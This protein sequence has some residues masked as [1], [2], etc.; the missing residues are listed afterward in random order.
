MTSALD[1][2]AEVG[3]LLNEVKRLTQIT[4]HALARKL[5]V[6]VDEIRAAEA[7]GAALPRSALRTLSAFYEG[8]VE[9]QRSLCSPRVKAPVVEEGVFRG[10][11][12]ELLARL[13]S[14]S[15]D[16]I[17][18]DIPYG[19]S[20]D[21][22]DVLHD[23]SNRALLGSSPAQK[24]AGKVFSK[25]RKPINGWS[26]Q[27][28]QIP[29][30]Y[31]EWCRGWARQ[32]LRVLKPGG[33]AV[34]FAGR[35]FAPRCVTALED[36]GFNF[37]DMLAWHKPRAV[38]RAQRLSTVLSKRGELAEAR[39]W[40]GWRV[41][42]LAPVFEPVIWCFKPYD[43]TIADNVLDHGVGAMNAER[44]RQLVGDNSNVIRARLEPDE[45]GLHEA[46]KPVSL[47][48][49]LIELTTPSGGVVLDPFAGS[50]TTGVAAVG[51]GR[52]CVLFERD[53]AHVRTARRRLKAVRATEA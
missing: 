48:R 26:S 7:R 18:S 5:G 20:L 30:Q 25:R 4:D 47:M 40:E 34:V 29:R 45:G 2:G 43:V 8:A 33:S 53:E 24:Q 31:Y 28:R 12:L 16:S 6:S 23:N 42:N 38:F 36:E 19:I 21:E 44:Y 50:G 35:R 51:C 1:S 14:A 15:I 41:G 32:W 39:R 3:A 10:D 9:A 11:C 46:Q 49:A 22:W 37:R 17:I 13:P 27:D 52:R